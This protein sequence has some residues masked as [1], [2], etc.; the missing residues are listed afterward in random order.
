M[1]PQRQPMLDEI[2]RLTRENNRMLHKMRR[3]AFIGRV[4]TIIFYAALLLAPLWFYVTYLNGA[5]Q[6]LLQAYDRVQGT[7]QQAESQYQ[8][9]EQALQQL[10]DK[11]GQFTST[12]TKSQ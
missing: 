3:S 5:V 12:S 4:V 2:L 9:F 11:F 8:Q 7:G 10:R 6:N 1:P